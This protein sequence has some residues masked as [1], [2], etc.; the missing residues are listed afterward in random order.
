MTALSPIIDDEKTLRVLER[1]FEL[2]AAINATLDTLI[3]PDAEK[4]ITRGQLYH[5]LSLLLEQHQRDY[6]F[7]KV[8]RRIMAER[9]YKEGQTCKNA[10]TQQFRGCTF[11]PNVIIH[12]YDTSKWKVKKKL[13][14]SPKDET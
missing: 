10:R 9:G 1:E 7:I 11:S 12:E 4:W 6:R 13:L 8:I 2:R 5:E 3:V 14:A